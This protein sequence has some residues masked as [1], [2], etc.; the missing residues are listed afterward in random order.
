MEEQQKD[1]IVPSLDPTERNQPATPEQTKVV[2]LDNDD[3]EETKED[4]R[5]DESIMDFGSGSGGGSAGDG[6]GA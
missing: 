5:D 2:N 4:M 6:A 1:R 3:D